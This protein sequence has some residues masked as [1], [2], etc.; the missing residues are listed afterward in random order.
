MMEEEGRSEGGGKH[1]RSEFLF[2]VSFNFFVLSFSLHLFSD[3]DRHYP[4]TRIPRL[5]PFFIFNCL[6]FSCPIPMCF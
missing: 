4:I 1:N 5:P 2:S 6:L 3:S